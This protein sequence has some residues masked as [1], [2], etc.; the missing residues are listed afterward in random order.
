MSDSRHTNGLR[1]LATPRT[2]WLKY[3]PFVLYRWTRSAVR[4]HGCRSKFQ[5]DGKKRYWRLNA[6]VVRRAAQSAAR[7]GKLPQIGAASG[8]SGILRETSMR[9]TW[10]RWTRLEWIR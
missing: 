7:Q 10:P 8:A 3:P 1:R 2:E 4:N 9:D 5:E 6:S